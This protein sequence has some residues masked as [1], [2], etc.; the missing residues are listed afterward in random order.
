MERNENIIQINNISQDSPQEKKNQ[1]SK[2]GLYI[3]TTT[4]RYLLIYTLPFLF[5]E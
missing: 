5:V 1:I 2:Y 3:G 4:Y